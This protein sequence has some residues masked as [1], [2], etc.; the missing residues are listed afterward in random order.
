MAKLKECYREK[1]RLF[2]AD[3]EMKSGIELYTVQVKTGRETQKHLLMCLARL[4]SEGARKEA[5]LARM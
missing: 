4:T 2:T 1:A 3:N 5:D